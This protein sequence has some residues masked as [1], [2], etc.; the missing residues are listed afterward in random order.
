M[1]A[2]AEV[3]LTPERRVLI[4][5][6]PKPLSAR[7]PRADLPNC[8]IRAFGLKGLGA[9]LV[10]RCGALRNSRLIDLGSLGVAVGG[11]EWERKIEKFPGLMGHMPIKDKDGRLTFSTVVISRAR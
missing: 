2:A 1:A 9:C 6:S 8:P 4:I 7:A 3:S 5:F 10:I 11:A